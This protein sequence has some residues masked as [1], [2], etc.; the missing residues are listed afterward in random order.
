MT[1]INIFSLCV[2][3]YFFDLIF[4]ARFKLNPKGGHHEIKI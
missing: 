1:F 2:L 4:A 3:I